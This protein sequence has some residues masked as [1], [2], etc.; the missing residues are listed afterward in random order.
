MFSVKQIA[1]ALLVLAIYAYYTK[2][3]EGW[4]PQI[5]F[6]NS[7]LPCDEFCGKIKHENACT[8]FNNAGDKTRCL[9]TNGDP[10]IPQCYGHKNGKCMSML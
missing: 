2:T 1:I 8:S 4:R 6:Y 7:Q 10:V 3:Y 5:S 9:N